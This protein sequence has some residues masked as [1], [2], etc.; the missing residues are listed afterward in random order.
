MENYAEKYGNRLGKVAEA[1]RLREGIEEAGDPMEKYAAKVAEKVAEAKRLGKVIEEARAPMENY[2]ANA[3]ELMRLTEVIKGIRESWE[4][5]DPTPLEKYAEELAEAKRLIKVV[6]EGSA[7]MEKYAAKVAE[8]K[9]QLE[10]LIGEGVD[11]ENGSAAEN[12]E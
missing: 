10:E 5:G 6:E 1:N 7:P 12:V 9:R 8:A 2:K 11:G 4:A 3:A